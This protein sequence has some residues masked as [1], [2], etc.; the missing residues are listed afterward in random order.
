MKHNVLSAHSDA[1]KPAANP[2]PSTQ[3]AA[4][5]LDRRPHATRGL[6]IP[7]S[8][9]DAA[10]LD[11]VLDA[12]RGRL[13]AEHGFTFLDLVTNRRLPAGG[14][15]AVGRS[16]FTSLERIGGLAISWSHAGNRYGLPVSV[17]ARLTTGETVVV[18]ICPDVE[19]AVCAIW[20]RVALVRLTSH[21]DA[22]RTGLSPRACRSRLAGPLAAQPGLDR[23]L[24]KSCDAQVHD[25]GNFAETVRALSAG[26]LALQRDKQAGL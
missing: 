21:V 2:C 23:L 16:T 12:V 10:Q 4:D 19:H 17:L 14:G 3:V 1:R 13:R 5:T 24:A 20:E 9:G 15:V 26:L 22:M 25:N 8:C 11:L 6:L 7:V 18:G